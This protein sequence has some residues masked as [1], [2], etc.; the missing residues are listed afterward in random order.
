[1]IV[2]IPFLNE[3]ADLNSY[4][5]DLNDFIKGIG[6]IEL[7]TWRRRKHKRTLPVEVEKAILPKKR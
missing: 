4:A 7:I 3:T 5:I 2:P 6:K 1:M